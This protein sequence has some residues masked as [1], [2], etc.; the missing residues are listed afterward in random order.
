MHG[1]SLHREDDHDEV[2][3]ALARLISIILDARAE[4]RA[5]DPDHHCLLCD[6][7][8]DLASAILGRAVSPWRN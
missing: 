4:A 2:R 1:K 5:E 3:L 7:V 6:A 8:D